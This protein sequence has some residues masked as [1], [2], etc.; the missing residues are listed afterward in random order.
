MQH[1]FKIF[2]S[3]FNYGRWSWDIQCI[4]VVTG[5]RNFFVLLSAVEQGLTVLG[6]NFSVN[7]ST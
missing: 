5:L 4:A 1:G 2:N 6:T 7:S 3:I